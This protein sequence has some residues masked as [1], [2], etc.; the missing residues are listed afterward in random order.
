MNTK[1]NI[2]VTARV[3]GQKRPKYFDFFLNFG[4]KAFGVATMR[5]SYDRDCFTIFF[6]LPYESR[7]G[8]YICAGSTTST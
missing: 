7:L 6:V 1:N 5:S 3:V 2:V 8:T 4:F